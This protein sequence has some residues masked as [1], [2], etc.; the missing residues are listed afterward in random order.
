MSH[1]AARVESIL[2]S[3]L[4]VDTA[5]DLSLYRNSVV[6]CISN[7]PTWRAP[8]SQA[9]SSLLHLLFAFTQRLGM[10]WLTTCSVI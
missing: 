10:I 5:Q 8:S 3:K 4:P 9:V 6:F 1:Q 2:L 7:W